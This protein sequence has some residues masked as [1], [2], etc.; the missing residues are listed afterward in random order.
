MKPAYSNIG[1]QP[2]AIEKG[3]Y[4]LRVVPKEWLNENI[5]PSFVTRKVET[6]IELLPGKQWIDFE[7]N[8]DSYKFK[9][10]SK[11]NGS[12][13]YFD[14][15]ISGT[16]NNFSQSVESVIQT[17]Q[18]HELVVVCLNKNRQR[19]VIGDKTKGMRMSWKHQNPADD[20]SLELTFAIKIEDVSPF[21]DPDNQLESTGDAGDVNDSLELAHS[22]LPAYANVQLRPGYTTKGLCDIKVIPREWVK[23]TKTPGIGGSVVSKMDLLP[24]RHWIAMK[25]I[26][27]SYKIAEDLKTN[28]SGDYIEVNISG[29]MNHLSYDAQQVLETLRYHELVV[30]CTDTLKQSKVAGDNEKGMRLSYLHDQAG[31]KD[32]AE[33]NFILETT[34]SA[35]YFQPGPGAEQQF[36][37]TEDGDFILTEDGLKLEIE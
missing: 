31:S 11:T 12:G 30:Y 23:I 7:L 9:E 20:Q 4:L 32:V 22:G 5:V 21:Y 18:Y 35:P 26:P 14:I 34:S 15:E 19:K 33:I 17:L 3:T 24:G 6:E 27:E 16:L 1:L 29:T 37:G 2:G 8:P 13:S 36:I 28:T 25:F 10:P